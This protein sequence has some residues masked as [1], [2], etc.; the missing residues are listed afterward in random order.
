VLVYQLFRD[1]FENA[2]LGLA[3][4][5][6]VM[7]FLIIGG[8]TVFQFVIGRKMEQATGVR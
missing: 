2:R 1:G 3:A 5:E 6:A 7:L 4:A 8:V